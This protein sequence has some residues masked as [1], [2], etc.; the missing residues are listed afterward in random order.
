MKSLLCI[1]ILFPVLTVTAVAQTPSVST[2]AILNSASYALVGLPNSSIAQGSFFTIFGINLGPASSPPI[3][4]PL[5]TNL[6]GVQ[7]KVTTGGT[8]VNAFLWYVSP[9]QINAI[10]P[11]N[12]PTGSA[13][14]GRHV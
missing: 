3:A 14:L 7:V 5:P 9:T 8:T 12:T 4:Y 1:L 6:G 10:L 13:T 2:N 11:E